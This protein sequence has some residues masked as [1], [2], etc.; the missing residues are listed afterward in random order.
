MLNTTPHEFLDEMGRLDEQHRARQYYF[1][2]V[3]HT[4]QNI[5]WEKDETTGLGRRRMLRGLQTMVDIDN[6]VQLVMSYSLYITERYIAEE[7]QRG[8][9]VRLRTQQEFVHMVV[10]TLPSI[11]Y[12]VTPESHVHFRN[13][14]FDEVAARSQHLLPSEIQNEVVRR[15][16]SDIAAMRH[17]VLVSG[18]PLNTQM[19]LLLSSEQV[20]HLQVGLRPL[21][22]ADG[23]HNVLIMTTDITVLKET[24][25]AVE[26]NAQAKKTFLARMSHEIRT[27]LNGVLG[28]VLL[29]RKAPLSPTQQDNLLT[30]QR[31]GRHLLAL[32][33]DVLDLAKITTHH[34]ELDAAS[35][36][37][38]LLLQG[39]G[40]IV[41]SLAEQKDVEL[42]VGPTPEL[43][44]SI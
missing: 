15:Q 38:A 35:F 3:L 32:I 31:V 14:A 5:Q 29:L 13:A 39:A 20:R 10:D 34:L 26:E 23:G 25:Q 2:R 40:E 19:P 24:W 11:I 17:S 21:P 7:E 16:M 36:D 42:V 4:R 1:E 22:R 30:M 12:V 37:L 43:I 33:N 9:E 28:M 41:A 6:S 18:Q 8:S 27:P 44:H